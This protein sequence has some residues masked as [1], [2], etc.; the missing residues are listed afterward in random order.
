MKKLK[1][2]IGIII[3]FILVFIG[4]EIFKKQQID[5]NTTNNTNKIKETNDNTNTSV[6]DETNIKDEKNNKPEIKEP[7]V[8]EISSG[9]ELL[10]KA[11]KT[12]TARGWAGASN[13]VIG[14]KEGIIY[15][16]NISTEEFKNSYRN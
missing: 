1:Y 8:T 5:D 9:K 6:T 13:H 3:I 4:I 11:E 2:L 14:L 12:L 16:Y 15:Y 7:S 10:E